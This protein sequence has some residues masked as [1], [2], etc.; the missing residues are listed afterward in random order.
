M[1]FSL[2]GLSYETLDDGG[3]A[4]FAI[5]RV[6]EE[7]V[8]GLGDRMDKV[9]RPPSDLSIVLFLALLGAERF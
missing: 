2:H 7:S 9:V 4:R 3:G 8:R 5:Y 6:I 1:F